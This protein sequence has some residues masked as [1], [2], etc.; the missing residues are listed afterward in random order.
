[1]IPPSILDLTRITDG[2]DARTALCVSVG[3]ALATVR[4]G[5]RAARA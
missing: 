1:M 2:T 5:L 3:G 4:A